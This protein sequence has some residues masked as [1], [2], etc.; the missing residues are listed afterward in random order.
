[1]A[2][3]KSS[4][5]D[6]PCDNDDE[7]METLFQINYL[8]KGKLSKNYTKTFFNFYFVVHKLLNVRKKLQ[9]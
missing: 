4:V 8:K 2:I 1:M 9:K 5:L 6:H 7:K 3:L